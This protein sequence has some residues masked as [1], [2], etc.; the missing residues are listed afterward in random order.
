MFARRAAT[1]A[2]VHLGLNA[3]SLPPYNVG[4]MHDTYD[5]ENRV[6]HTCSGRGWQYGWL[7]SNGGGPQLSSA[8]GLCA[9]LRGTNMLFIGDSL[10]LQLYESWRARLRDQRY[11][12]GPAAGAAYCGERC[13]GPAP[14]LCGGHC[15]VRGDDS[16][17]HSSHYSVC[18]NGATL[19]M[20]EAFRWVIDPSSFK[21]SDPRASHCARRVRRSPADFGLEVIPQAH[22]ARMVETALQPTLTPTGE[23]FPVRRL[24]IVYNQYAHIHLFIKLLRQCYASESGIEEA[25][26]TSAASRDVMRYWAE[27]QARWAETLQHV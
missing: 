14:S 9:P 26:A 21:A 12:N 3:T 16:A 19:F 10:S 13:E 27:D 23:R 18:D 4:H 11:A 25:Y 20:A 2:W 15:A 17:K 6:G 1:G 5:K 7:D 22:V 24:V 8:G